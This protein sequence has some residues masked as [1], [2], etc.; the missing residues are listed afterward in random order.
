MQMEI[1][2]VDLKGQYIK[3]KNEID[4]ALI[5]CAESARYIKGP[6]VNLFEENLAAYLNVNHV[7]SCGNGTDALQIA[8]MAL[9]LQPGDEVIV[10]AFTYVATA[11]AIG[12][13]NLVPVMAVLDSDTL[14]ISVLEIERLITPRTRAVVPVHIYGQSADMEPLMKLAEKYGLY[15]IEDNAQALGAEY[16]F[17]D[18]SRQKTGIIGHIGCN[19]FFPTKN[20][21]GFGDGGAITTNDPEL[22]ERC[23]MISVHGQKRKYYHEIIGCNSRLDTIQ[24]AVL[25]VKLKYIDDY[26]S[27]RREAASYYLSRLADAGW[28]E[29]PF[30][31]DHARHSFNQFTLKIKGDRRDELQEFLKKNGVPSIIYYPYPLYKQPAFKKYVQEGMELKNTESL[32]RS[33]LSVPI[34]TELTSE[35]QD[36]IV[37]SILKFD[38]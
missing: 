1:Q 29:L 7:V 37:D 10:P 9:N 28:L 36:K 8:L 34:H 23:R 20:L 35:I 17:S 30:Q 15:V 14:N 18:G 26:I 12:L 5:S 24:A 4:S 27:A 33:V 22:A 31:A 16:V 2:M 13:L 32:C 25:N 3:I 19:S 21:G 6:E 38:S 11:E